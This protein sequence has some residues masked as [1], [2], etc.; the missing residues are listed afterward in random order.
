MDTSAPQRGGATIRLAYS[1]GTLRPDSSLRSL[2]LMAIGDGLR[3]RVVIPNL[4][5]V[6]PAIP[7]C[8]F[9]RRQGVRRW[10]H[11]P[12]HATV[13][14]WFESRCHHRPPRTESVLPLTVPHQPL[15]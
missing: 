1:T 11:Q 5:S 15:L 8:S 6:L 10:L 12:F 2:G 13:L 7:S 3:Q 4:S 9:S 14:S